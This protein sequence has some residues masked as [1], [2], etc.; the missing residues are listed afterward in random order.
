MLMVMRVL[1]PSSVTSMIK[2]FPPVFFVQ[3]TNITQYG[4]SPSPVYAST[5]SLD[6]CYMY[7]NK[8]FGDSISLL[9]LPYVCLV[10]FLHSILVIS[11]SH[12]FQLLVTQNQ[13]QILIHFFC[14]KS[15]LPHSNYACIDR[16]LA[17]LK[18]SLTP[19]R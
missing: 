14:L 9:Y 18:F 6:T 17:D 3:L 8:Q 4:G 12:L 15:N 16:N 2:R 13:N 1:V 5:D 10:S 7:E 19:F 11:N